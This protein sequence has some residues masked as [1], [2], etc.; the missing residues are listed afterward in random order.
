MKTFGSRS[1]FPVLLTNP[2]PQSQK[3]ECLNNKVATFPYSQTQPCLPYMT[4]LPNI[5]KNMSHSI[6]VYEK[7]TGQVTRG[8]NLS[9]WAAKVHDSFENK[10]SVYLIKSRLTGSAA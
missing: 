4:K 8:L 6:H 5:H 3:A 10:N 2:C 7:F 9:V 1:I